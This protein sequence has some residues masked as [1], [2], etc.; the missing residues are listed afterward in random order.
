MLWTPMMLPDVGVAVCQAASPQ[1]MK[2]T[3]QEYMLLGHSPQRL[4]KRVD[5]KFGNVGA[6]QYAIIDMEGRYLVHTGDT[7][8]PWAGHLTGQVGDMIY[9]IQG[10]VLAGQAVITE[11]EQALLNTQGD[12][13]QKVM[14]AME[15]AMS[16]GGD[17]RCASRIHV[18]LHHRT[19]RRRRPL[20]T[21]SSPARVIRRVHAVAAVAAPTAIFTCASTS[22]TTCSPVPIR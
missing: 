9:T 18:E 20:V 10:N 19:S 8:G 14:A 12:M 5:N 3:M 6:R 21:S 22:R 16:M 1:E 4:S 7:N 13:S 2:V 17:G 15:A 11:A